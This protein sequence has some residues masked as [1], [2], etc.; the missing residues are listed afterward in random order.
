MGAR[1]GKDNQEEEEDRDR[2]DGGA[3]NA[4]TKRVKKGKKL[5]ADLGEEGTAPEES[6]HHGDCATVPRRHAKAR[7]GAVKATCDEL[8]DEI[9]DEAVPLLLARL[10]EGEFA[11]QICSTKTT[12]CGGREHDEL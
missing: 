2:R 5:M 4:D 11:R 3:K 7:Q 12:A 10:S 8:L 9:E 1:D 6:S